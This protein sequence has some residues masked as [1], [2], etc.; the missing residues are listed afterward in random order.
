VESDAL[1][2]TSALAAA[3]SA[4]FAGFQLLQTRLETR[5]RSAFEEIRA[6]EER[7]SGL[8]HV[9]GE[10]VQR[11]VVE[12]YEREGTTLSENGREY[13]SFLNCLE[14]MSIAR[15]ADVL[16]DTIIDRYVATLFATHI[17]STE[18]LASLRQAFK[19]ERVFEHLDRYM[20]LVGPNSISGRSHT[21]SR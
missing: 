1:A 14:R 2:Y 3:A 13:L 8:L 9:R 6:I 5:R 18:T 21:K 11:E 4:A 12:Y 15:L 19:D 16:D 10:M 20:Q 17:I 7:L